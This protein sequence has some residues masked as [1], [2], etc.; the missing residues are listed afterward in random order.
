MTKLKVETRQTKTKNEKSTEKK[1]CRIRSKI[2]FWG[3]AN[4][5]HEGDVDAA[6]VFVQG[7][8]GQGVS[9]GFNS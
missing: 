5:L 3:E 8:G 7:G 9:T 6:G 1:L 4:Y 2:Y